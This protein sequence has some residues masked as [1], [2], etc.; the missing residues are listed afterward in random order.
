M[1]RV[2]INT[3]LILIFCFGALSCS[4]AVNSLYGRRLDIPKQG[5]GFYGNPYSYEHAVRAEVLFNRGD[6]NSIEEAVS[7]QKMAIEGDH[8]D[9]Y[10][11]L[12]LAKMLISNNKLDE[13]YRYLSK[14]ALLNSGDGDIFKEYARYYNLK[15][16][17]ETALQYAYEGISRDLNNCSL[18]KWLGDY[19]NNRDHLKAINYYK[20]AYERCPSQDGAY[21]LFESEYK[22]KNFQT[23]FKY[24]KNYIQFGQSDNDDILELLKKEDFKR[25]VFS[26]I[27]ILQMIIDNDPD[28]ENVRVALIKIQLENYFYND[29]FINIMALKDSGDDEI[30]NRAWWMCQAGKC[31]DG[32][33]YIVDRLGK[34]PQ[35]ESARITLARI[36][37]SLNLYYNAREILET[38]N[39][40]WSDKYKYKAE[41][42]LNEISAAL[43][44]IKI[45]TGN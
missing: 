23:A 41:K 34:N 14:A 20:E 1:F 38:E 15:G 26:V 11:N 5:S 17:S 13:A 18:Y 25:T 37:M 27:E 44:N 36:H 32:R 7:E 35:V 9:W 10:L 40:K 22:N 43:T 24:L 8:N 19:F 12:V 6:D 2:F 31:F 45:E 39:F 42:L 29:A 21:A 28:D 30:A 3:I 33:D 16:E 4:K